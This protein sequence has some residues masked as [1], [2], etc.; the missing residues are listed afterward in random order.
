MS[1]EPR[2]R[3]LTSSLVDLV[4]RPVA[5][6]AGRVGVV[7]AVIIAFV[8]AALLVGGLALADIARDDSSSVRIPFVDGGSGAGDDSSDADDEPDENEASEEKVDA[9]GPAADE[10]EPEEREN[11]RADEEREG[12]G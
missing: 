1:T 3:A 8:L 10:K 4:R 2:T 12:E 11:E 9:E 7:P 6:C 5:G